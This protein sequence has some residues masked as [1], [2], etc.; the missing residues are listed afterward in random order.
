MLLFQA[1]LFFLL[2]TYAVARPVGLPFGLGKIVDFF[3]TSSK[4]VENQASGVWYAQV[5]IVL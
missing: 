5:N 4:A 3:G 1:I 2:G